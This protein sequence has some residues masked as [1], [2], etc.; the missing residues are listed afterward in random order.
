MTVGFLVLP[1]SIIDKDV[2]GTCNH[3]YVHLHTIALLYIEP[4]GS[5]ICGEN[6]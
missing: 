1:Q 6:T 5:I 2:L 3:N 4:L